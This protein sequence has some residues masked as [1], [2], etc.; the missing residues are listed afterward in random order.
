MVLT[1]STFCRSLS[2]PFQARIVRARDLILDLSPAQSR[3]LDLHLE[4]ERLAASVVVTAQA[5]PALKQ[6]LPPP[7]RSLL[8]TNRKAPSR[9]PHRRPEYTPGVPSTGTGPEGGF[10]GVFLNGGNS[11]QPRFWSMA[12]P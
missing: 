8:G 12:P 3:K 4:L 11:Y 2:F 5:E 10:A 6:K 1:R 9:F 7:S